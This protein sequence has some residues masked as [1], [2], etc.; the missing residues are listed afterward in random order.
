[1][2]CDPLKSLINSKRELRAVRETKIFN[3]LT[4][5]K[6]VL[7]TREPNKICFYSCGPTVWNLIHIGNLRSAMVAD[8]FYRYW[9]SLGYEVR[10]ARNYTDV[11]DKI[12][13]KASEEGED[14]RSL[15]EKFIAEVEKDYREA[16]LLEPNFKP[17]VTEYLDSIIE[18]IQGIVN[19]GVGYVQDGN[20]LFSV[21]RFKTYGKL[22]GKDVEQL[23]A[24]ARVEVDM[25]KKNPLDFYLWKTAKEGELAWSSPWGEGRPGW[26][27]ECSSMIRSLFGDQIDVHHGG[28]DLI[29]PHHENE[30]AQSE[31]CSSKH[32]FSR[33]WLHH[34][35][36]T[37]NEEKMSKSVGNVFLAREFLNK[38]G[39]EVARYMM[40][41]PH[42]RS[43]IDFSENSVWTAI[44]SLIRI[45]EAK[46]LAEGILKKTGSKANAAAAKASAFQK[47]AED[48]R[49]EMQKHFADD[50]ATPAAI[51][52]FF[53]FIREFNKAVHSSA[54]TEQ[55]EIAKLFLSVVEN[56]IGEILGLGF[57]SV[58]E[59]LQR[60]NQ[61]LRQLKGE[62]VSNEDELLDSQIESLL[63]E[64]QQARLDKNFKRADE[65]RDLLLKS[66]IE[67]KD[68]PNGAKWHR[69]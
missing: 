42:Y 39:G 29:F 66:H 53:D 62:E 38:F 19:S 44:K 68:T 60:L 57:A 33:Y 64:R 49:E 56:P 47:L 7:E 28:I 31:A 52:S 34:E 24:G 69:R 51:A 45:Y 14:P 11:D 15:S 48:C 20:V 30:I 41:V 59:S 37:V 10:Y 16:G 12:I 2:R 18:T 36:V 13:K 46:E 9:K 25:R 17:K 4:R 8:L 5:Q 54:E 27:I 21:D 3:T 32:P 55:F 63:Q 1:M 6:E 40:L 26:H 61:T 50:M 35:F 65:I 22:S 67:I 58:T 43:P 23:E